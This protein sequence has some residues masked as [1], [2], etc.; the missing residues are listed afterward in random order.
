M[1]YLS[2]NYNEFELNRHNLEYVRFN[3]RNSELD[4]SKIKGHINVIKGPLEAQEYGYIDNVTGRWVSEV[5]QSM[6]AQ[7][8]DCVADEIYQMMVKRLERVPVVKHECHSC[9]AVLEL[10]A[11]KHIFVC[12]YCGSCYAIGTQRINA[13]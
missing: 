1:S 5:S 2:D 12:K 11:D 13:R 9:G 10:D 3:S 4:I 7:V 6:A 8:D